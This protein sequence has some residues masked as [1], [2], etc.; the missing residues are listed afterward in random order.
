MVHQKAAFDRIII[1]G[2]YLIDELTEFIHQYLSDLES[3]ITIVYNEQY[4]D[5]GSGYSLYKGLSEVV[6]TEF[7]EL[8][9]AEGDLYVDGIS[10]E[11]IYHSPYSV[12]TYNREPIFANKAVVYY[13]DLNG[14]IHYLYDVRHNALEINE[15]FRGI[16]NSGQIWKF[17]DWEHVKE[18][19]SQIGE[20]EWRGTNLVFIQKYFES[21]A[22]TDFE[23]IGL[24]TW[25]NCNT[26]S[27]FKRIGEREV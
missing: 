4:A 7:S 22:G 13:F 26:I 12:V 3:R 5:W 1:V 17:T 6:N 14:G 11:E 10:F 25:L 20:Q 15:P 21:L 9:F 24:R 16:F 18:I 23:T 19:F 27:D 2:G 8:L